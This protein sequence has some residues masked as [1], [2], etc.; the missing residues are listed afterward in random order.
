MQ[1]GRAE[2]LDHAKMKLL[3]PE[4]MYLEYQENQ[5]INF[6][7]FKC[8]TSTINILNRNVTELKPDER[9][10]YDQPAFTCSKS[11]IKTLEQGAKYVQ[12]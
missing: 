9:R 5:T 2:I 12:S 4:Q 8:V 10:N 1:V 7:K 3:T 6:S 11:T